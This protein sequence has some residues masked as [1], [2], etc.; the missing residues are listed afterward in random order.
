MNRYALINAAGLVEN[1]TLWDG[2][3]TWTPPAGLTAVAATAPGVGPG[4]TYDGTAFAPPAPAPVPPAPFRVTT[5]RFG[6]LFTDAEHDAMNLIRW[7]CGQMDALDRAVPG[8]PLKAAETLFRKF[9]LPA[10]FIELD[11]SMV[12]DGL[13]LLGM[14]GVFGDN[15]VSRIA[16][17]LA[18]ENPPAL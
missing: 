8:N 12:S 2:L 5:A 13:G 7:Q 4:W 14:L 6:D 18:N 3:A 1:V 10:E 17:V 15:A 16:A 9:N 11:L